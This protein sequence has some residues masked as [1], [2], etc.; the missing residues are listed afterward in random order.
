MTQLPGGLEYDWF[1]GSLPTNIH[2]ESDVHIDSTYGF[3]SFR[4]KRPE[5]LTMGKGSGAYNLTT[6]NVGPTGCVTIGAYTCLNSPYLVCEESITIGSHCLISWGVVITDT[7]LGQEVPAGSHREA[8]ERA[9]FDL[10]RHLPALIPPRPVVIEDAVWIGF[11]SVILPGVT[12]GRGCVIG[13]KAVV[14]QDIPPYAVVAGAPPRI[15]RFLN[16]QQRES[17][18]APGI[19]VLE[20]SE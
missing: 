2:L 10:D 5:A 19:S 16:P 9:A 13:C 15:L 18:E 14:N 7:A 17:G 4:S 1:G 8:L 20:K 3:V 11:G 6:F 12:L